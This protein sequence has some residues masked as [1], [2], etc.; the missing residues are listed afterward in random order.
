MGSLFSKKKV[1]EDESTDFPQDVRIVR[2]PDPDSGRRPGETYVEYQDRCRRKAAGLPEKERRLEISGFDHVREPQPE[3]Q[4]PIRLSDY[5]HNVV[6]CQGCRGAEIVSIGSSLQDIGPEPMF[7]QTMAIH[8]H[9]EPKRPKSLFDTPG[10]REHIKATVEA[11]NSEPEV[12]DGV[13]FHFTPAE[14]KTDQ[15]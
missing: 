14:A 8:F 15:P 12:L 7:A 1:H 11:A 2:L 6:I 10:L 5:L 13:V 4:G 3:P 9:K